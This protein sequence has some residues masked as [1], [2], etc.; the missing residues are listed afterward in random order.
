MS[1]RKLKVGVIG[2]GVLGRHH[3]RLYKE[4]KNAELIGIYDANEEAAK[5]ISEEFGL[6]VFST[7]KELALECEA[8][9]IAVPATQ[10]HRIAEVLLKMNKHL[11]IEKPLA[12]T[13]EQA[14]ELV[15]L[16]ENNNV[17]IEVGHTERY[18][19]IMNFLDSRI[20]NAMFI[21]AKRLAPYPP[22]RPGSYPRG[23]EVGVVLDL[24]IH[25]LELILHIVKSKVE[26]VEASGIHVLSKSEDIANARIVFKNGCVADVTASRI[27]DSPL[28]KTTIY[29]ADSYIS[30]DYGEKSGFVFSKD[31][32]GGLVKETVPVIDQNALQI[33]LE[34]F[35]TNSIEAIETQKV[36]ELK[37]SG[38]KGLEALRLAV[39]ITEEI[40]RHNVKHNLAPIPHSVLNGF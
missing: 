7:I 4:C 19:P 1:N 13:V 28:R 32:A 5:K 18:N 9:S 22:P 14:G 6:K 3:A 27:S 34:N 35:V 16:A 25:D 26:K 11:L 21:E 39:K 2:V 15:R 37:V 30:L 8:L 29:Q 33:E 38:K 31:K 20:V 10:H 17:V 40:R 12:A 36:P 23:T 24:M